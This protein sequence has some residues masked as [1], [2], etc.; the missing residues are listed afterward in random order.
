MLLVITASLAFVG[1]LLYKSGL[2]D[3]PSFEE[4]ELPPFTALVAT[5]RTKDFGKEIPSLLESTK[6]TNEAHYDTTY[7]GDK[8]SVGLYI[9]DP[10]QADEP[11]WA[12][13]W[14]VQKET[15]VPS[16]ELRLVHWKGG[17]VLKA[18]IP[19]RHSWTPMVAPLLHWKR[20][21]ESFVSGGD[22]G[23]AIALEVYAHEAGW[24]EYIILSGKGMEG[25]EK[26]LFPE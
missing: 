23:P 26:A 21:F 8:V 11:R 20:G 17:S 19:W 9:D 12:L 10:S 22:Q 14:V 7:T 3:W 13:G 15:P 16:K 18:R 2:L 24:L 4:A 1:F 6:P 5:R 25:M